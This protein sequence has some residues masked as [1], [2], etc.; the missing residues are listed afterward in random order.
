M[1]QA[2]ARSCWLP[3]EKVEFLL[4]QLCSMVANALRKKGASRVKPMR[5][6]PWLQEKTSKLT[7]PKAQMNY[8]K[9]LTR[10]MGGKVVDGANR[11]NSR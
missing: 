11:L 7:A 2:Y 10:S 6:M 9:A 8:L 3:D 5:F 1:W 4:A